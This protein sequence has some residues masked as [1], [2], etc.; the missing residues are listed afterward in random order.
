[1]RRSAAPSRN[2]NGAKRPR[3]LSANLETK[4]FTA[5]LCHEDEESISNKVNK[6]C[7]ETPKVV[8]YTVFCALNTR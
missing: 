4:D 7:A 6:P 5:K 1:M 3:L 8:D 2:Q